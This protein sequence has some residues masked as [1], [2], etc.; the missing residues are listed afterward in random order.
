MSTENNSQK[1]RVLFVCT[2]NMNRSPT[3][4]RLF[5]ESETYEARSAG[6]DPLAI[7][8]VTQELI[9][10]ADIVFVMEEDHARTIEANYEIGNTPMV[11]LEIPD[12]F[13]PEDPALIAL[14]KE[15]TNP[16][17]TNE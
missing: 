17:M 11:N 2:V 9:S 7:Q 12:R 15:R 13:P 16:Y 4:E 6:V 1:K 14:I 3:A 5:A 10:W 8:P